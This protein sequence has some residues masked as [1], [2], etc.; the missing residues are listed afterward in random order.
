MTG[1]SLMPGVVS[2]LGNKAKSTAD[3]DRHQR[4]RLDEMEL[5]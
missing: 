5:F 2:G 1:A 4:L 3:P